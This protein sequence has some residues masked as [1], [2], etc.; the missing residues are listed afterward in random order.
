M[1]I[2]TRMRKQKAVYWAPKELS[3][4]DG[5]GRKAFEAPVEIECRWDDEVKEFVDSNGNKNISSSI[6]YPD[7]DLKIG[8]WLFLGRLNDDAIK[9]DPQE[10]KGAK[11]IKGWQKFPDLKAV[12]FL[13]VAML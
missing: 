3:G 5:F 2:I 10:T 9:P 12:E 1:S 11:P 6:V 8:G 7:R 13:R 4:G